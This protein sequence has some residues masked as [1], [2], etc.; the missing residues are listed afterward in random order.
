[1]FPIIC[2]NVVLKKKEEDERSSGAGHSKVIGMYL[3]D[4]QIK[5]MQFFLRGPTNLVYFCIFFN[6]N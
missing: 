6:P 2:Q 4:F 1:M 3:F 5:C